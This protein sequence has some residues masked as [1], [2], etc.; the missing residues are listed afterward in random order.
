MKSVLAVCLKG[1]GSPVG[2]EPELDVSVDGT[3]LAGYRDLHTL[4]GEIVELPSL[5][6][7]TLDPLHKAAVRGDLLDVPA[8]G[9]NIRSAGS[10]NGGHSKWGR[11]Q[12]EREGR[13][14]LGPT[15]GEGVGAREGGNR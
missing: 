2:T 1:K 5:A 4:L 6:G 11:L 15:Q 14:A 9:G 12:V 8:R 3:S 10:A 7:L 13:P